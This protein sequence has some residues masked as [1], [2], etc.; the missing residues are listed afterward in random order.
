[1][2]S[3]RVR[4]AAFGNSSALAAAGWAGAAS[5]LLPSP[6]PPPPHAATRSEHAARIRT[7]KRRERRI[8][9]RGRQS[10][11]LVTRAGGGVKGEGGGGGG[12]AE[13]SGPGPGGEAHPPR[14]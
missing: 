3:G 8:G 13:S 10:P 6:P 7:G 11:D 1:M 12:P 14:R 9:R 5:S 2:T 4:P